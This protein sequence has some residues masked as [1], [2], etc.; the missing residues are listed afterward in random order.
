MLRVVVLISGAATNLRALLCEPDLPVAVVAIGADRDAPGLAL[1]PEFGLP[2]FTV[3]YDRYPNREAW[4]EGLIRVIREHSPDIVI[5]SG[6]MR[7]V[8]PAVVAAFAPRLWN[9][10]PA[11]LPEY[12]GA[13]AVRDALA[14]GATATGASLIEVDNTVDGGPV[15]ARER[16][17]IHPDDTESTLHERIKHVERRLVRDALVRLAAVAPTSGGTP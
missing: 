7:L 2:T 1:G 10:H 16:V 11:Y 14:A 5:L 9:T 12:P 6:L 17:P 4:G 3:P 8:P 15:L 13:H